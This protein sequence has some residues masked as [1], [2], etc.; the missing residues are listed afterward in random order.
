V[1][2]LLVLTLITASMV[3]LLSQSGGGKHP[4]RRAGGGP[5]PPGGSAPA[6]PDARPAPSHI[7]L[8]ASVNTLFDYPY[9]SSAQINAQLAA[10]HETGATIGRSDALWDAVELG[11]PVRGVHHYDWRFDDRIAGSLAA[12]GLKWLPIVDYTAPWAESISGQEHSPPR[13]NGDF[14]AYAGALAVRYGP[15][16]GFWRAH[17]ELTPQP[18]DTYEIWNEPDETSFWPPAPDAARYAKLYLL[19]RKAIK[20]AD[21][22]ARVIIG[23]LA[24]PEAFLPALVAASPELAG[25]V[26][27][28]AVHPYMASPSDVLAAVRA[29]RALLIA[30]GMGGVPLYV[31]EVGWSTRP[32]HAPKWAPPG[33]R[34]TYI[35]LTIGALAHT[36]CA[37]AGTVIYSWMTL[38]RDPHNADDWLGIHSPTG[39]TTPD[40][41]AFAAALHAAVD[42]RPPR[43]TEALAA[44]FR[45]R[46]ASTP[47]S[48][49]A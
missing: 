8:G 13:S 31:T 15:G 33:L 16:G 19:A 6:Q 45:C 28:V 39:V 10:L 7:S 32:P 9:Y 48:G 23:G 22:T 43:P 49:G 27:G 11:P 47:A 20:S 44:R 18:V 36:N 5:S 41:V 29:D 14:A 46:P 40:S 25:H 17:P 30:H 12:H 26:D 37:V 24:H 35:E 38:Q 3:V 4:P 34:P 1:G 2:G 21:P 42:P